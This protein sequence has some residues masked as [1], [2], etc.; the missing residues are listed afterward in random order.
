MNSGSAGF[1]LGCTKW[2]E[3]DAQCVEIDSV[4]ATDATRRNKPVVTLRTAKVRGEDRFVVFSRINGV[5]KREFF[6]S[7]TEA[8]VHHAAIL[9]KLEA[10]GT[11]A[12]KGP[13][14]MTVAQGWREFC[15]ARLPKLKKGSHSRLLQWWWGKF[16]EQFGSKELRDMKAVHIDAFLSKP[17]WSGTTGNQGFVYLRLV[18]NWLV[19]YELTSTNPVLKI[20]TP[21]AAPEHHLLTVPEVKRLL[22]LTEKNARLRAWLVLGLFGGMRISEV[23]RCEPKHIE[24]EEIFIPIRKTTDPTPRPRFV[25]IL[26]ALR[27]HLPKKWPRINEDIIKRER[28]DLAKKMKWKEWPQN[29]LRHTAA[30]MHRAMW[31]DSSK[32]A[33]FLGHSSARMVEEKYARGVRKADAEKFWAL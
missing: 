24:A 1:L 28:T 23:W 5:A 17:G 20:D 18:W 13:A 30:S 25:P 14:G 26:P 7:Q 10:R 19:R 11:E 15:L 8:R 33:Y 4:D 16:V 22:K 3:M 12:F 27:R 21:K 31:Q 29:C 9:D 6:R 2:I 32:T